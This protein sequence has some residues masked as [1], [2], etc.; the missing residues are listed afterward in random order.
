MRTKSRV[1][2]AD[3][4]LHRVRR[5][6]QPVLINA[7][8]EP[9]GTRICSGPVARELRARQF[10]EDYFV[11]ARSYLKVRLREM[12]M[13]EITHGFPFT[14]ETTLFKSSRENTR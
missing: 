6:V 1:R 14:K 8:Q 11:G 13:K 9:V 10:N 7:Q 3:G 2:R 4:R 5:Y 12:V